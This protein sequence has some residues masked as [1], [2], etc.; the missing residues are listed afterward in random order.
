MYSALTLPNER[1]PFL[2]VQLFVEREERI[3]EDARLS[4][5]LQRRRPEPC[6]SGASPVFGSSHG[7]LLKFGGVRNNPSSKP[8]DVVA[9]LRHVAARIGE[10]E[11]AADGE[12]V[13]Q[14]M[15]RVESRGGRDRK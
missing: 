9:A 12:T 7:K 14:V 8:V 15:A 6:T 13:G 11:V 2:V 10:R 1:L 3:V 5:R 4:G